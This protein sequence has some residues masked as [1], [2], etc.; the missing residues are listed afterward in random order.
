MLDHAREALAMIQN[1]SRADLASDRIFQLAMRQVIQ[2]VGEAA[3]RVS[4]EGRARYP[5]IPWADAV[6][7]RNRMIHGYD[8]VDYDIVWQILT[9]EFPALVAALERALPGH[10]S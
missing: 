4:K 6:A 8:T 1:R 3:G 7:A 5:Y 9:E 2:I 10:T